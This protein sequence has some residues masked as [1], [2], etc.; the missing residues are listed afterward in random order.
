MSTRR[1]LRA[2]VVLTFAATTAIGC[3]ASVTPTPSGRVDAEVMVDASTDTPIVTDQPS[4]DVRRACPVTLPVSG[5]PCEPTIDPETCTDPAMTP[6]GCPPGTGTTVRCEPTSMRWQVLGISCNP[7]PPAACPMERPTDGAPCPQGLYLTTPLECGYDPCGT[8]LATQ[9]TCAGPTARWSVATS[10][11][12]PPAPTC[13]T[14]M[15][16]PG[17]GCGLPSGLR[18]EWGDCAGRPV[19]S[20]TCEGG[21]WSIT[22]AECDPDAGASD[23]GA[24]P[25]DI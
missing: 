6:A 1:R 24:A 20:G 25:A 23:A 17:S 9:A 14:D 3:G 12:N 2:P 13:P 11:S 16:A 18:C 4:G 19:S 22:I 15:P 5:T 10:S 8:R 21:A 7:P